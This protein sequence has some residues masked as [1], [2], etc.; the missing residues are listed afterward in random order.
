MRVRTVLVTR[1]G[2]T[3]VLERARLLVAYNPAASECV[4]IRSRGLGTTLWYVTRRRACSS[5][6]VRPAR[7]TSMVRTHGSNPEPHGVGKRASGE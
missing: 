3:D 6:A 1:A 7:V 2:R 5:T 4:G